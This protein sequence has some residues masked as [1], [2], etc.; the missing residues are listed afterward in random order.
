MGG[1]RWARGDE[2]RAP[3]LAQRR[4]SAIPAASCRPMRSGT[5]KVLPL[6][7]VLTR[8]RLVRFEV[9]AFISHLLVAAIMQR[10]EG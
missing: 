4:R 2:P 9:F 5:L 3:G 10:L 8:P 6:V 7:S 1:D